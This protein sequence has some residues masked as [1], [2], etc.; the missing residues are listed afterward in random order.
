M[1]TT[2][3]A[4]QHQRRTLCWHRNTMLNSLFANHM[5]LTVYGTGEG[6]MLCNRHAERGVCVEPEKHFGIGDL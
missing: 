1:E 4:D 5:Y 3:E 2:L 6:R